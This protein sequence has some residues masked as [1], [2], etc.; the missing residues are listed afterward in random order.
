[1]QDHRRP[2]LTPLTDVFGELDRDLSR[3]LD[4]EDLRTLALVALAGTIIFACVLFPR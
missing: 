3:L 1:M 2:T 4:D